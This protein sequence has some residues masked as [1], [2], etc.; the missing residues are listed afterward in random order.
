[1]HNHLVMV[2]PSIC[3]LPVYSML[4]FIFMNC[5]QGNFICGYVFCIYLQLD[6]AIKTAETSQASL[7]A[8]RENSRA[9]FYTDEEFKSLQLQVLLT[10]GNDVSCSLFDF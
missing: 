3:S 10:L 1:M 2:F 5:C 4:H 7:R 8:E 6:S 9:L